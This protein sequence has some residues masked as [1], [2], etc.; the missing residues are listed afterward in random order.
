MRPYDSVIA[1]EDLG[2]HIPMD[3]VGAV[4]DRY[5]RVDD[6]LIVEFFDRHGKIIDVTDVR[7]SQITVTLADFFNGERVALL[8]DLPAHHLR[9]VRWA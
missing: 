2:E 1:S 8:I 7:V 3:T 4:V 9:G 5:T 6:V